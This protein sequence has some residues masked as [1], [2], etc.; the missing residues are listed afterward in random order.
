MEPRRNQRNSF[1]LVATEIGAKSGIWVAKV[2]LHVS[3]SYLM[4]ENGSKY[5]YYYYHIT[6]LFDNIDQ[7]L[8]CVSLRWSIHDEVDY[9]LNQ[10]NL[11]AG[12]TIS[13][14]EWIGIEPLS[15]VKGNARVLWSNVPLQPFT[16]PLSGACHRYYINSFC[17]S[18][19][20]F[21]W[22]SFRF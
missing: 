12:S 2:L 5:I 19:G 16:L 9:N 15:T 11:R 20:S 14:G 4:N 1:V 22:S 6:Q 13:V 8:N 17:S 10:P 18:H 7:K 3:L 21:Y